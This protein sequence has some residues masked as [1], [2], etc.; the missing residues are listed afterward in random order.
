MST[1]IRPRKRTKTFTG[2]W[3]C[4]SRKI[5]CDEAKPSCHQC[6]E[7]GLACEGYSTRLQWL[8]PATGKQA[9]HSEDLSGG[10][11]RP[12]LRRFLPAAP[13]ES[14]LDC[15]QVDDILRYLDSLELV[16]NPRNDEINAHMENFGV[17]SLAQ[18]SSPALVD[19]LN[20]TV[21][22]VPNARQ[23]EDEYEPVF[24]TGSA[25][26]VPE[27]LR[28]ISEAEAA[29]NLCNLHEQQL[30]LDF[31]HQDLATPAISV[32]SSDVLGPSNPTN[33]AVPSQPLALSALISSEPNTNITNN[34]LHVSLPLLNTL[35]TLVIPPQERLLMAHYRIRVVN[36]FCVIDNAK[37][38]WKTIHLPRVTQCAGELSFGGTTTRIRDALRKSLLSISAFYLSNDHRANRHHD[39]AENWGTIASRYR[40]DAIGLLKYA[41]ET[42]FYADNRPKYKEF[43]ATMLSMVMSGDTS[44]CSVHLDGAEKLI[45]HMNARKSTFSRK[46][47]SLH[48]IYLYLRVIYESTAVKRPPPRS[49]VSRFSPSLGSQRTFGPR[50]MI[51]TEQIFIEDDETSPSTISMAPPDMTTATESQRSGISAYECIYGIPQSLLI[52]LKESIEVID[53]VNSHRTHPD[54]PSIPDP[55][56]HVCDALEQKIMDWPLEDRLH[57]CSKE[58]SDGISATIIYHQT[59]AF[60]SALVIFFSQSVRLISHRY[61]RQY[62]QSILDSIEAVEELKAETK[63]LAAPLFWPAFMGATEAFEPR[64]QDR[65]RQWYRRVEVYGIEAVRTGIQ[66][67]HEVWKLGPPVHRQMHSGWRS[68]VERRGDC[69]MLT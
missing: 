29:W 35:E 11:L 37:S 41:V 50:P 38:P 53:E 3:T 67:V 1:L 23:Q 44:T 12:S 26:L 45:S 34:T 30:S 64:Q 31:H 10:S 59:R 57:R 28:D 56:S 51:P 33:D 27:P 25:F 4:R 22:C 2:C 32:N 21:P 5:K 63:I 52:L 54:N 19:D 43:L 17:F 6:D 20:V 36:L 13:L 66:V 68:V 58:S 42:D 39:E 55:L 40:C 60:L 16:V 65:F 69:L 9:L 18:V 48:R 8:T 61:L 15:Q 7:K 62:V 47:Q 46:A 49:G 24:D 14:T